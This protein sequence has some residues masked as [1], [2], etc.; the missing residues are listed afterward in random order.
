MK[1]GLPSP[2]AVATH[3]RIHRSIPREA[4][5][6]WRSLCRECLTAYRLASLELDL[7]GMV[8]HLVRL[9]KLPARALLRTRGGR[10]RITRDINSRVSRIL[11]EREDFVGGSTQREDRT[12]SDPDAA[13]VMRCTALVRSGFISRAA[14]TLGQLDL[15]AVD[16]KTIDTLR[17]LH[18]QHRVPPHPYH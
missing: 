7:D 13:R 11:R 2:H 14:R 6:A 8:H 4:W 12:G 5:P 3:G 16:A 9:L 18:P 17:G 10:N 1:T 15:P